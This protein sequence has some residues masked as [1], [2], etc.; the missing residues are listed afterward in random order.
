MTSHA[1]YPSR[2]RHQ[3][4]SQFRSAA[5][6]NT[7]SSSSHQVNKHHEHPPLYHLLPFHLQVCP[8]GGRAHWNVRREAGKRSASCVLWT[9]ESF[10]VASP[11]TVL[12]VTHHRLLFLCTYSEPFTFIHRSSIHPPIH[13]EVSSHRR[14]RFAFCHLLVERARAGHGCTVG[15][16]VECTQFPGAAQR[17]VLGR[18]S[19]CH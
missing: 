3:A 17:H 9:D 10:A 12:F 11:V 18:H 19:D 13:H 14:L 1:Y 8:C 15:C 2:L 5:F 7:S 16:T 4:S 6:A